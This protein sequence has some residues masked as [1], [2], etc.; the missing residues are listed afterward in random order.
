MASL[1]YPGMTPGTDEYQA[2]VQRARRAR[3]TPDQL[4]AERRKRREHIA[5]VR[6]ARA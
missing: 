6:R 3:M 1:K 2:A 4:N 5:R